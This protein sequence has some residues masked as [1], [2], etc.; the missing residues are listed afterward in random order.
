MIPPTRHGRGACRST[1]PAIPVLSALIA[2]IA[3]AP[4]TAAVYSAGLGANCTHTT[5]QAA[6]N[7]AAASPGPHTVRIVRTETWTATALFAETDQD[8]EIVGGLATCGSTTPDGQ[9]VLSG[10]GNG[11]RPVLAL[12]GN[13]RFRVRGF[14]IRGGDADRGGG[15]AF[16][17][18]GSLEVADSRIVNNTALFGGGIHASGLSGVA[19]LILGPNVVV[20]GNTAQFGGGVLASGITLTMTAPGSALLGN[21]AL[22]SGGGLALVSGLNEAHAYIGSGGIVVGDVGGG[23]TA[24]TVLRNQ[25]WRGAGIAVIG[26]ENSGRLAQV[27]VFS[28]DPARPVRIVQNIAS[29]RGGGI[30]LQTSGH[31][32]NGHAYA[33]AQLRHAALDHN[34][35]PQGAAIYIAE[36]AFGVQNEFVVSGWAAFN[37]SSSIPMHPAAAPCPVGAPCGSLDGNLTHNSSGAIVHLADSAAFR[38]S[39]LA[40]VNND[41]GWLAYLAGQRHTSLELDNSLIVDNHVEAAL[42]GDEHNHETAVPMVQLHYLTIAD[43]A[44]GDGAL[45]RIDDELFFTRSLVQSGYVLIGPTSA[46]HTL[47]QVIVSQGP[48]P[49]GTVLD[50]ARFADPARG[51]FTPRAG[52]R[53]VDFATPHPDFPL[54]LHSRP[55]N[56]DLPFNPNESGASDAGALER[57]TL[58]PL[59]LNADFD[60]DLHL[61][62]DLGPESNWDGSQNITGAPGSGSARVVYSL[63]G[64]KSG[65]QPP[66][67]AGRAQCIHL[68]GPG[69]YVLNGWGRVVPAS[70]PFAS[71]R[72]RLA[73]ELRYDAG[74]FGCGDGAPDLGGTHVLA[75][76]STW[77]RPVDAGLIEVPPSVWTRN[78]SLTVK[79]DVIGAPLNP[80]RAW[81]DGISLAPVDIHDALFA[82]G[83]EP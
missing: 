55:R 77:T 75:G 76:T 43:N 24:G 53:A 59:V 74:S 38:A 41:S 16:A 22:H 2:L 27:Q 28:T 40:I 18:G 36:D 9:T 25:A 33:I 68:P 80:P 21:T 72:A 44:V 4:A 78:T 32:L 66:R 15:I 82:D 23:S 10:A 17:G 5:A 42:I 3:A 39:R 71:N 69:T 70:T 45:L 83:F 50:A 52:A 6:L 61:W 12:R 13:G 51:D 67:M 54:D 14:I 26:E 64:P 20:E 79:L 11:T 48:N 57:Q 19:E 63:I 30:D 35:A 49:P 62:P 60:T 56:I 46:T 47:S 37:R 1:A 31:H 29:G 65:N 81:F 34:A 73:W 8:I 7:A 58:Q